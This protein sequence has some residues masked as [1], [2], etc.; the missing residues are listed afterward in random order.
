VLGE[1][2]SLGDVGPT[3]SDEPG[4][5]RAVRAPIVIVDAENRQASVVHSKPLGILKRGR[6]FLFSESQDEVPRFEGTPRR[7]RDARREADDESDDDS[8]ENEEWVTLVG[9]PPSL[10]GDVV[11]E[12]LT[13]PWAAGSA[14]S[15]GLLLKGRLEATPAGSRISR[16]STRGACTMAMPELRPNAVSQRLAGR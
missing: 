7:S 2:L 5:P 3:A 1:T 16:G 13:S 10:F 8:V 14:A 4:K 12:A 15:T 9:A 11:Y 6:S